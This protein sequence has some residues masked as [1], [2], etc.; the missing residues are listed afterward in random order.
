MPS[1]GIRR[2]RGEEEEESYFISMAD[3]MVGLVFVFIILLIYFALQYQQKSK[4]LSDAGETRRQMLVDI[5]QEIERRDPRMRV[6]VDEKSGVLR[7][8]AEILFAKGDTELS[9]EGRQAV[10]TI[11][12]ALEQVLPCYTFP[13]RQKNC[14]PAAHSLDAMFIEGHTDS[15]PLQGGAIIKGNLELSALRATNTFRQMVN[16]APALPR[17]RNRARQPV[18]SV[19]GYGEYRQID[20]GQSEEAKTRN[21]R[22]DLRFLMES[23]RDEDLARMLVKAK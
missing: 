3:M 1:Q 19:S 17:L 8:P 4:A 10:E 15:D 22:I 18:L 12:R 11:A 7:L 21:R 13:R 23:P 5:K 14:R 16:G 9:T 6:E 20:T 2:R